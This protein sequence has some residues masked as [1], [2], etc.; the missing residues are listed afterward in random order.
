MQFILGLTIYFSDLNYL[1]FASNFEMAVA[2]A[3]VAVFEEATQNQNQKVLRDLHNLSVA[4]ETIYKC[5][6]EVFV[7]TLKLKSKTFGCIKDL[8]SCEASHYK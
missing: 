3:A 1:E 2:K 7:S 5:A 4:D 6:A 8:I